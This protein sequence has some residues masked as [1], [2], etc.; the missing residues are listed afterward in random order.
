MGNRGDKMDKLG[1]DLGFFQSKFTTG[2]LVE[3]FQSV[4]GYAAGSM[5]SVSPSQSILFANGVAVGEAA[6]QYAAPANIVAHSDDD[7]LNSKEITYLFQAGMAS[8]FPANGVLRSIKVVCALPINLYKYSRGLL[9][10]HLSQ[11]HQFSLAD[12]RD[13]MITAEVREIPQAYAT[14]CGLFLNDAG[15]PVSKMAM[16]M[17]GVIDIGGRDLNLLISEGFRDNKNKSDTYHNGVWTLID[18][19]R[20]ALTEEFGRPSLDKYETETALRSGQFWHG[21][22]YH[23]ITEMIAV[24]KAAFV[25]QIQAHVAGLWGDDVH[26]LKKIYITGGGALLIGEELRECYPQSEIIASPVLSNCAGAWKFAQRK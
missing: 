21:G 17:V 5:M 24:H 14:L 10:E 23:T 7:W 18:S 20:V 12:G 26:R 13:Y 16:E 6:L 15:M 8:V 11:V 3:T 2:D 1:A 9:S 25:S 4:V 22:R 19:L